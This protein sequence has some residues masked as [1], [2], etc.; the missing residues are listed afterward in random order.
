M[1]WMYSS[2]GKELHA[3]DLISLKELQD[4]SSQ[5]DWIWIDCLSPDD[6]ETGIITELLGN[7]KAII[8]DM[9]DESYNLLSLYTNYEKLHDYT[10]LSI[11]YSDI[12]QE[13][14]MHPIYLALKENLIITWGCEHW[15]KLMQTVITK[16]KNHIDEGKKE[17]PQLT[18][19][20]IFREVAAKNSKTLVSFRELI[21][22]IEE[23]SIEKA[24]KKGVHGVFSLKKQLANLHRLLRLQEEL[25]SDA[26]QGVIPNVELDENSKLVLEDSIDD[27]LRGLEFID[28]YDRGLDGVLTLLNL[29]GIHRV[30]T[31]INTLTIV[32]VILTIAL[33]AFELGLLEVIGLRH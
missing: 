13:L 2:K 17:T 28:S 10:L 8:S 33:V 16:V 26:K 21:D 25:M 19:S 15:P 22:R 32:L 30:E 4:L 27:V 29:G 3:S 5:T 7:E 1:L 18:L 9:K 14:E 6:E 11:A 12:G 23:E 31:S 24:T 20:R